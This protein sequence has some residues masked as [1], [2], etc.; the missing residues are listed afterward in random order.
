MISWQEPQ[1]RNRNK[2][3]PKKDCESKTKQLM[4]CKEV[5]G[6]PPSDVIYLF[7]NTNYTAPRAAVF[8]SDS[9]VCD[10]HLTFGYLGWVQINSCILM[11]LNLTTRIKRWWYLNIFWLY[12][13]MLATAL[14]VTKLFHSIFECGCFSWYPSTPLDTAECGVTASRTKNVVSRFCYK[15]GKDNLVGQ[16]EL[17]LLFCTM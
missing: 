15:C 6:L 7:S 3:P 4:K 13:L 14:Y 2:S 16:S 17:Q 12:F 1:S 8:L 11:S 5:S 10:G 9:F